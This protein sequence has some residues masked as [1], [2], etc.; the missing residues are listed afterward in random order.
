MGELDLQHARRDLL[1]SAL[2]LALLFA[3]VLCGLA[4]EEN[5]RKFVR[6]GVAASVYLSALLMLTR[7]WRRGT[8]ATFPFWPF[9]V[10]A[11]AAELTSG[12]LRTRVAD[13]ITFWLAPVAAVLVGGLHW[14]ALRYWR[15]LR[16]RLTGHGAAAMRAR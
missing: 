5:W 2:L 10:A 11:A 15:T 6:V 4:Y 13:G 14:L 9:A 7:R 16:E 8:A 12:W 1:A 3:A